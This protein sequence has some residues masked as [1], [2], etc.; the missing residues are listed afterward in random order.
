MHFKEGRDYYAAS[1]L[2][3]LQNPHFWCHCTA[4]SGGVPQSPGSYSSGP[5]TRQVR[6][7][8]SLGI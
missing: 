3:R 2:V 6:V 7:V 8:C 5:P 1:Q 4:L